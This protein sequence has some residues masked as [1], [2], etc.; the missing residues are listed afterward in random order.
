M[1]EENE[2]LNK[3]MEANAKVAKENGYTGIL[4]VM[5]VEFLLLTSIILMIN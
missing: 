1:I 5:L 3:E 4:T 2:R